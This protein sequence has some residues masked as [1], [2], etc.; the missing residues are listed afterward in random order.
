MPSLPVACEH[1]P[2]WGSLACSVA[3]HDRWGRCGCGWYRTTPGF[4]N[5][6]EVYPQACLAFVPV[7]G[8]SQLLDQASCAL[9]IRKLRHYGYTTHTTAGHGHT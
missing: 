3:Y 4:E 7:H 9:C 1:Q 5:G 8:R 6:F 2:V